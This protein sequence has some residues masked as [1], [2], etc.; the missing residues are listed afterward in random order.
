M[1]MEPEVVARATLN[2]TCNCESNVSS[3]SRLLNL[4]V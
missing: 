1:I 2:C 4:P 3:I